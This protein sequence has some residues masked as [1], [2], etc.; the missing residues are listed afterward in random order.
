MLPTDAKRFRDLIRGMGRMY[1]Q[2]PDAVVLDAYWLALRNW[3]YGEFEA[4]AGHLMA[5]AK[6]MPRPAEFNALRKAGER[7]AAEA[8][9]E[10]MGACSGW[11]SGRVSVDDRIDRA[12]QALGGYRAL[13]MADIETQLPHLSRRFMEIYNELSDVDEARDGVPQIAA[14][15]ERNGKVSGLLQIGT[16]ELDS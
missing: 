10:A 5:T 7:T 4:A 2:D 1:G 6:F 16:P 12:V 11:R 15:R 3:D 13:A 8:W 9:N 14:P